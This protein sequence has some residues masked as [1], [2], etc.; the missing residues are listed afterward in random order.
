MTAQ[1]FRLP[2]PRSRSDQGLL[3]LLLIACV[4]PACDRQ[5]KAEWQSS[6]KSAVA[7][8]WE[9]ARG[10]RETLHFHPD[11]RLI[12]DSPSEHHSCTYDFPDQKHIRLDCVAPEVPHKPETYGFALADGKLMISDSQSTGTYQRPPES[13]QL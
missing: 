1:T 4:F 7:G 3:L 5:S 8:D 9:E 11:G 2:L 13:P 12:M 10:T 6:Y